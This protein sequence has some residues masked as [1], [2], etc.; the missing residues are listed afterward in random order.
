MSSKNVEN[1]YWNYCNSYNWKWISWAGMLS[2]I[3]TMK[4]LS[5]LT[6]NTTFS[7]FDSQNEFD[8]VMSYI[9]CNS[10][11]KRSESVHLHWIKTEIIKESAITTYGRTHFTFLNPLSRN[12]FYRLVIEQ[13]ISREFPGKY[14]SKRKWLNTHI[15]MA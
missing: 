10:L 4:D 1:F 14:P 13:Y 9:N 2:A 5:L 3:D 15:K 6:N 12:R 11:E 7:W 8:V